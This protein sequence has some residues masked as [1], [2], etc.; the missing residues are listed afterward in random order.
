ML[1]IGT[2]ATTA[3]FTVVDRVI[4]RDVPYREPGRLVTVWQ[5]FPHWRGQPALDAQWDRIALAYSE[6]QAVAALDQDFE[7]V[8][9]SSWRQGLRLSGA[10]QPME[11][12]VARGG[13]ALLS[14]LGVQPEMGR[15]FLPGE[16]GAAA[17][18]IAVLPHALW[19]QRFGASPA[20]IGQTI[21]LDGTPFV[22]VGVL[23]ASFEFL[24]VSPFAK[25]A[26]R[27]AIWT[28][29]GSWPGDMTANSQNY[30]V[31]ARLR[32][33]VSI[34]R[35]Q[36]DVARVIRG[37]RDPAQHD[38]R[39]I[40]RQQA[41]TGA[42]ASPLLV[43]FGAVGV[44][45]AITCGNLAALLL[46]EAAG[47]EREIRTRLAV[48]ATARRIVRQLLTEHAVLALAGA[49]AGVL[50]ARW[51][52]DGLLALAP[53]ELPHFDHVTLDVRALVFSLA[54]A[55]I[56][57]LAVGLVP[58][59]KLV[60]AAG[61]VSHETRSVTSRHGR[62]QSALIAV[63]VALSLVLLL[64]SGLLVRTLLIQQHRDPGFATDRLLTISLN[65][66]SHGRDANDPGALQ[67]FY[68]TSIERI[69]A[70]PGVTTVTAT[71]NVPIAGGGGQWSISVDPSVRLSLKAPSAQHDE[72]LP[73]FFETMHIPVLAGRALSDDDRDDRPLVAV[74]NE[75]MARQF[76]PRE[77][78]IGKS[79]LTPNGVRTIVGIVADIRERGLGR[80][81]LP[82]LYQSVRQTRTSRQTLLVRTAGDPLV[83]AESVR[84]AIW[85]VDAALPVET[86][87]TL[88]RIVYDSLAPDRYRVFLIGFFAL[89]A[90]TMTAI[91]IA[92]V[93]ARAIAAEL[94]ELCIRMAIGASAERVI[95]LL[96][97]R[98][99]RLAAAGIVGGAL[100]GL[101]LLKVAD[102]YLV[103]VSARDPATYA[104]VCGGVLVI[105]LAAA[106]VPARR[107]RRISLA[108]HLAGN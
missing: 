96:V 32:P 92:G 25:A 3:M 79:F 95:G 26:D 46:G 47:R 6:Y 64:A 82:T 58:A 17:P 55:S 23:P 103:G 56:A 94:R 73:G 104:I 101:V 35:V 12:S 20:A 60:T 83:L 89:V 16:E 75:T 34:A 99:A 84:Q 52:T 66:S 18:R 15:W 71:S 65:A 21:D 31:I 27:Q 50:L 63:Q 67:R 100:A 4:V 49:I 11:I 24:S 53:F 38:A 37:N 97:V 54:L 80:E 74:V 9:A 28:P 107:V 33:A 106:W 48:G 108:E 30:E 51:F 70:F 57:T 41:E 68:D 102:S 87:S 69:Q 86:I 59:V 72:V 98:Y 36:Q 7:T 61:T 14:I 62:T 42:V 105:A 40:T 10:G 76:W 88:D 1:A 29:I 93:T 8:G 43:L 5:T 85:S 13:A 22:I 19:T 91:G 77:S 2:G 78:P 39:V 44:L 90:I 45:F 81:P